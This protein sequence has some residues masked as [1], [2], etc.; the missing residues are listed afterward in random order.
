[1]LRLADRRSP[2]RPPSVLPRLRRL[3]RLPREHE[4]RV[5]PFTRRYLPS[6]TAR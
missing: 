6:Q 4:R 3:P 5:L 1:M 2:E